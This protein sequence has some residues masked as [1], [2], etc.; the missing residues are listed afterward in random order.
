MSDTE[1][2]E[3]QTNTGNILPSITT[4]IV[5]IWSSQYK[6]FFQLTADTSAVKLNFSTGLGF[7]GFTE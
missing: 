1:K 6:Q 5:D 4:P 2:T 3:F 7:I